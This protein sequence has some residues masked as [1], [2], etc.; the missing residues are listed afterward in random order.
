MDRNPNIELSVQYIVY[1]SEDFFRNKHEDWDHLKLDDKIFIRKR[2]KDTIDAIL[3]GKKID[4]TG[5]KDKNDNWLQ[6]I[7]V[8]RLK[9]NFL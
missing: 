5:V 2:T 6:G 1:L 8:Q 4:T 3:S 9:P 7:E